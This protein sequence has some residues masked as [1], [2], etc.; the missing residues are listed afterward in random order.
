[1][2]RDPLSVQTPVELGT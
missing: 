1:M 2:L